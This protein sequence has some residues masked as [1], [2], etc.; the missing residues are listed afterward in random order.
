M[1]KQLE[2]VDYIYTE[3]NTLDVYENC[4][5]VVDLDRFLGRF[6][7]SRVATKETDQGWGDALYSRKN[8]LLLNGTSKNKRFPVL[9]R[10]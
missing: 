4:V 9:L 8:K 7:F 10:T 3:I 2:Y 1:T 5:N 6:G